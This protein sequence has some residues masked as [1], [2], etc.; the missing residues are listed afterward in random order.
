M[1]KVINGA[2]VC[3]F[4]FFRAN[5]SSIKHEIKFYSEKKQSV[6]FSK[7]HSV[8]LSLFAVQMVLHA[9]P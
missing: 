8:N 3:E 6:K 9:G 1:K 4:D 7:F 2:N 5:F